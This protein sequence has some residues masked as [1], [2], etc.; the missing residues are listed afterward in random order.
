MW[1]GPKLEAE[2]YTQTSKHMDLITN[3]ENSNLITRQRVR[4]GHEEESLLSLYP[5]GF[6]TYLGQR[7]PIEDKLASLRNNG[8]MFRIQAPFGAS[9]RAIEQ[10][11]AKCL[12]LNS[13]D[14]YLVISVGGENTYLWLGEG[15]NEPEVALG[16]KLQEIFWPS[17]NNVLTKEGEESDEF[18]HSLGGKS[19]YSSQKDTGVAAGFEPRLFHASNAHGYFHV[20]EIF[21]FAQEDMLNDDIMLLDAY[22]TIYVWIGN[23]SNDFEKRGAYKT[24]NK[25]IESIQDERDKENVQVVEIEAGKEPPTFT[26]NFTAWS[27]SIAQKWLDA[28]PIKIMKGNMLGGLMKKVEEVKLE[29]SKWQDPKSNKYSHE[30]LKGFPEGVDPTKKEEYMKDEEFLALFG[31]TLTAFKD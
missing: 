31:M 12:W 9:A 28:D 30:A 19:E 10:N 18:W 24:A 5:N 23:K 16:R 14:A 3:F 27:Q 1:M 15:A 25:Y 21:N 29:E 11:E 20:K 13:G 2:A 7:I 17:A 26:I 6:I 22:N 8:G 4:R